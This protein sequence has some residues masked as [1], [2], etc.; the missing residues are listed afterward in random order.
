MRKEYE[1]LNIIG[2]EHA[3]TVEQHERQ[4]DRL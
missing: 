4:N 1:K 3:E 2:N